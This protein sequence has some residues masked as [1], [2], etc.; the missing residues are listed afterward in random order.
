[1]NKK[2][3]F[4]SIASHELKTPV[5]SLK[6]NTQ[7]FKMEAEVARD[8]KK[9]IMFGKMDAQINKL[10][11]LI[12]DLL[13]TSKLREGEL[14]YNRQPVQFNEVVKEKIDE[15]QRTSTDHKIILG[16]NPAVSVVADKERIGQVIS[17]LLTN[18]IKYCEDCAIKVNTEIRGKKVICSVHDDGIGI[19]KEEKEKIFDRFYRILGK[20]LHTYPG[21]WPGIIYQ[22]RNYT[23]P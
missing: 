20:N 7:I 12:T 23:T 22:Q 8:K 19:P 11:S 6:A 14:I 2:D 1:M 15:L 13:D 16:N 9:A 3:D 17:N 4:M 5:S 10:T 21:P 18:A